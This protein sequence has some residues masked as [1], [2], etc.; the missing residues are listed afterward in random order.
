MSNINKFYLPVP[1]API[2]PIL[3]PPTVQSSSALIKER[4]KIGLEP[5]SSKN[6]N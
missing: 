6:R 4:S 1:T 2:T 5:D 3:L